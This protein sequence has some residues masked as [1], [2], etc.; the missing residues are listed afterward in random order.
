MTGAMKEAPKAEPMN[1][2]KLQAQRT[3][4]R[5]YQSALQLMEEVG[6]ADTSIA[7]ITQAAGVST[8]SFYT[9]FSSKEDLLLHTFVKSSEIYQKAYDSVADLPFP[10]NL[11]QFIQFS[12]FG[13]D[14]RGKEVMYGV[15][16]NSLTPDF[17]AAITDQSRGF[18]RFI[19]LLIQQGLDEGKL[20]PVYDA[21]TYVQ[22]LFTMLIGVEFTWCIHDYS[23]NLPVKAE[24]AVKALMTGFVRTTPEV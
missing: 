17:K 13:L 21:E 6:Y 8:G 24:A 15:V 12:Y 10:E 9:Y 16:T 1:S 3:K 11:Y 19:R 18:Y 23:E 14:Q 4:E 20:S 5:I 2:R 22:L 7:G